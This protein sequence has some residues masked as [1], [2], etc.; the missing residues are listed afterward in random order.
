M[1]GRRN[2][3]AITGKRKGDED[4]SE[5]TDTDSSLRDE[6][7]KTDRQ[8]AVRRSD[9]AEKADDVLHRARDKADALVER[10]R[11]RADE[12]VPPGDLERNERDA[13]RI[14]EDAVLGQERATADSELDAERGNADRAL[15]MLLHLERQQTDKTLLLERSRADHSVT[16]R[17]ELLGIVSHDVRDL[18]GGIAL[19]AHVLGTLVTANRPQNNATILAEVRRIERQTARINALVGDLLDV[20]NIEFG[21]FQIL[22]ESH[23]PAELLRETADIFQP[24]AASKRVIVLAHPTE[25]LLFARLDKRRVMQVLANLVS[26]AVKFTPAGGRVELRLARNV[27]HLL[28]SVS[29]TGP[30]VPVEQR[31]A[32]FERFW[33]GSSA[34]GRGLGLGLYISRSVVEA[35]GGKLWVEGSAAGSVFYF[36]L[37]V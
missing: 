12:V 8:L 25:D 6:R 28:F 35:H 37:P 1:E 13:E 19:S 15:S 26:N 24:M 23:D 29:D 27:D 21:N 3:A 7:A 11:Q 34:G 30:G 33:Q 10:T 36:T 31:S 5:R 14:A 2:Q 18:L 32:I 9:A 20:T 16:S 17:D 4:R 22:P